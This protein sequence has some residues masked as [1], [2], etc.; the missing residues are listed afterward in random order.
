MQLNCLSFIAAV[1]TLLSADNVLA[2]SP[3]SGTNQDRL[4][5]AMVIAVLLGSWLL[6]CVGSRRVRPSKKRWWIFQMAT[7]LALFTVAGPLDQWSETSAAWHMTQHML[8]MVVIAPLWVLARPLP[9]WAVFSRGWRACQIASGSFVIG[10]IMNSRI[11][12]GWWKPLLR[13]ARYPL[14]AASLHGAVI[15]FWHAPTLYLLALESA[16]W[17]VVEH[18]CF[19]IT[20]GIFWWSVLLSP[21][22]RA[23]DALLALLFTLMHTGFLG[24]LLTFAGS[25]L[26][27]AERSLQSQQ[28]AGLIMWVPG[29]LPYLAAVFWCGRRWFQ[30]YYRRLAVS[31]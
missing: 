10:W 21:H 18:A 22:R 8:M 19:L 2:H 14:L 24:A 15:W 20:A 16:W 28:L 26:Y 25:P 31:P 1:M 13:I 6:Y 27:G 5:N 23:A 12:T 7:L 11:M 17:H 3:F 4:A 30:Q 9:Q 29:S